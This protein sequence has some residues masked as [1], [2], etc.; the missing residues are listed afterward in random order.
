MPCRIYISV[1]SHPRLHSVLCGRARH[2]LQG[3]GTDLC[4]TLLPNPTFGSKLSLLSLS[5]TNSTA[6]NSPR[7]RISPTYPAPSNCFLS[8]RSR[9]LPITAHLWTNPSLFIICCTFSAIAHVKGCGQ[10][11]KSAF[12]TQIE[13][14]VHLRALGRYAHG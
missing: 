5:L 11:S 1:S 3:T 7:P 14:G 12:P 8:S 10:I 9:T 13:K 4:C 2:V 6:Q